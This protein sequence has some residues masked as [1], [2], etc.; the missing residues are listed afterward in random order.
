MVITSYIECVAVST[1]F[2]NVSRGECVLQ[3]EKPGN[4]AKS[5]HKTSSRNYECILVQKASE[6]AHRLPPTAGRNAAEFTIDA[7][8]TEVQ[9]NAAEFRRNSDLTHAVQDV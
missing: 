9:A 4:V 8:V 6:H 2:R 3:H 7:C 5:I 1:L